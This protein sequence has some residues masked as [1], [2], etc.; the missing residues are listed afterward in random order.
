M[1]KILTALLFGIQSITL[2]AACPSV[3]PGSFFGNTYARFNTSSDDAGGTD[4]CTYDPT[5]YDWGLSVA[6]GETLTIYGDFTIQGDFTI[7]GTINIIGTLI[8][9][10][11]LTIDGNGSINVPPG[12]SVAVTNDFTNGS[13]FAGGFPWQGEGSGAATSGNIEGSISVGGDFNNN[14]DGNFTIADGGN[15]DIEGD[16]NNNDGADINVD[17]GGTLDVGQD[18]NSE[19]GSEAVIAG[20]GTMIVGGDINDNGGS[21]LP[22]EMVF[23]KGIVQSN[24]SILEWQ[25]AS[26]LNNEGFYIE[27]AAINDTDPSFVSIGFV[28]GNGT[29]TGLINYQFTD[30]TITSDSYYRLRQVDFDGQFEY[31]EMLRVDYIEDTEIVVYPNPF[32]ERINIRLPKGDY[33]YSLFND[34]G[35]LMSSGSSNSFDLEQKL[36]DDVMSVS[37]G[38]YYLVIQDGDYQISKKL[39]KGN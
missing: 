6:N 20:G 25:T 16:F 2:F 36:N 28:A 14:L 3:T 27:R 12:G 24:V 9:E 31:S 11:D 4:I 19:T 37:A 23:F 38:N 29:Y 34:A 1:M 39:I 5:I 15:L 17:S 13:L 32:Y 21:V 10:G 30:Q 33:T 22:V 18:F 7:Y 8:V 26:E 35:Q